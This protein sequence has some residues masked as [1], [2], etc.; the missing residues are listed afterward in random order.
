MLWNNRN[1]F[2]HENICLY[3]TKIFRSINSLIADFKQMTI[4]E[5]LATE[6]EPKHWSPPCEGILKI[7]IDASFRET[8]KEAVLG[9]DGKDETSKICFCARSKR[10]GIQF[11]LQ[12]ELLAI[13]LGLE[14]ALANEFKAIH[15]EIDS[16][17]DVQE[18]EKGENSSCEWGCI[19]MDI[20]FVF[21]FCEVGLVSHVRR[22]FNFCAHN[23][24]KLLGV[25]DIEGVW[26]GVFPPFF[27]NPDSL[28]D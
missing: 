26:W 3:A 11:P 22:T 6:R 12:A 15:V 16:L 9:V 7:N 10:Y 2:Y 20:C 24:A 23:L 5:E 19:V 13:W 4:T 28:N 18:I 25:H 21:H 14:I 17:L 27:C 1:K 8:T